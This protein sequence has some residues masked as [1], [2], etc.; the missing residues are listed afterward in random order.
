MWFFSHSRFQTGN[1]ETVNGYPF[2]VSF[3]SNRNELSKGK[4]D[5]SVGQKG[6][7]SLLQ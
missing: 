4:Y 6:M 1:G 3:S 5:S 2:S 7:I